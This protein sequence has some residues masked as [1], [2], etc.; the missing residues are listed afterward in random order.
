MIPSEGRGDDGGHCGR[1]WGLVGLASD[2]GGADQLLGSGSR[3]RLGPDHRLGGR[4]LVTCRF[5]LCAVWA[6]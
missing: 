6:S 5:A 4:F 2:R 3:L 1:W